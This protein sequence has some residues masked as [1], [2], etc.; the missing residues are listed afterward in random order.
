MADL[1]AEISEIFR[2]LSQMPRKGHARE[3]LTA[4][5]DVLFWPVYHGGRDVKNALRNGNEIFGLLKHASDQVGCSIAHR[6]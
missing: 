1:V 2:G 3:D 6:R 4:R 5:K